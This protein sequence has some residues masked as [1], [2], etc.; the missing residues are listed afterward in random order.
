M[1]FTKVGAESLM[2]LR[3]GAGLAFIVPIAIALIWVFVKKEKFTTV[4]IG[5]ATFL[6]FALLIEKPIQ[7]LVISIDHP[8]SRFLN[9]HTVAWCVVVALFPGVFEETGRLVAFKTVLKKRKNKETSIS[10]GIGHGGFEVMLLIGL[11]YVTSLVYASMINNGTFGTVVSQVAA[12]APDQVDS[13]YTLADQLTAVTMADIGLA[14]MERTFAV[15]FH[16][17][18]SVIVF[19]ACKDSKKF[20]LYP[21]AIVMHTIMDLIAALYTTKIMGVSTITLEVIIA[22][23]AV[24]V[25]CSAYFLLYRKDNMRPDA[26]KK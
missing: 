18:L 11:N 24:A 17:A 5:A 19:Y 15:L 20:R 13:L 6:L 4:L 21:L 22:V 1:E 12:T 23:Y 3:L 16:I 9:Q 10:Y 7:A 25:F 14:V 26:D 2:A 8:V